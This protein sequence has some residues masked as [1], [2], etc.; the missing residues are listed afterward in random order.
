[1]RVI[2]SSGRGSVRL[3][4]SCRVCRVCRAVGKVR[5]KVEVEEGYTTNLR[6]FYSVNRSTASI[7]S[8]GC[9]ESLI[10]PPSISAYMHLTQRKDST[11]RIRLAYRGIA[12]HKVRDRFQK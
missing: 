7:L 5:R 10:L 9:G 3:E 2:G 4:G 11:Q 6:S 12:I 8:K 1:M